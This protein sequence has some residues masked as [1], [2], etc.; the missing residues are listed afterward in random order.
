MSLCPDPRCRP[1]PQ[2]EGAERTAAR[3]GQR[4]WRERELA[5]GSRWEPAPG[6][7]RRRHAR[8]EAR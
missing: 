4:R 5:L 3:R 7:A 6:A 8:R 1:R 2:P